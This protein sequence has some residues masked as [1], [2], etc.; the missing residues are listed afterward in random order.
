MKCPSQTHWKLCP[1][2][3]TNFPKHAAQN[4]L[5]SH[6]GLKIWWIFLG[7]VR[8]WI[9]HPAKFS[10]FY[11]ILGQRKSLSVPHIFQ[12]F[13]ALCGSPGFATL[14]QKGWWKISNFKC[15][16]KPVISLEGLGLWTKEI[17]APH[18]KCRG[19]S[20]DNYIWGAVCQASLTLT[21]SFIFL[22]MKLKTCNIHCIC[23]LD[24]KAQKQKVPYPRGTFPSTLIATAHPYLAHPAKPSPQASSALLAILRFVPVREAK[25]GKGEH[26]RLYNW[27]RKTSQLIL[28]L[29][30]LG[31]GFLS[32]KV[33]TKVKDPRNSTCFWWCWRAFYL[34]LRHLTYTYQK[35]HGGWPF[36]AWA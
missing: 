30:N 35:Y 5:Y 8:F 19:T 1:C 21:F 6:S 28:E 26:E 15:Q 32:E 29:L 3:P 4:N 34:A 13:F 25:A 7:S 9:P 12:C 36:P 14:Q 24:L 18:M 20:F 23:T 10:S 33:T 27:D 31:R 11:Q 17:K 22:F 2:E 16:V